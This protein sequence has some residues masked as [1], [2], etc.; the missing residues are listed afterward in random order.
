MNRMETVR[1]GSLPQ[2]GQTVIFM[3]LS[4]PA[5]KP[6]VTGIPLPPP[7]LLG[8]SPSSGCE[9]ALVTPGKASGMVVRT[10]T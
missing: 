2:A 9:F 10:D 3:V 5:Y 6:R 1:W 7:F 4:L 8:Y